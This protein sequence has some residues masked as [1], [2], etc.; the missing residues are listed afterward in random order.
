VSPALRIGGFTGLSCT[1]YPGLLSAVVFCQG[2]PW[3]CS[4][5]HNPHLQAPLAATPIA[6]RDIERF[7]ERRRGL[8]DAVVFS[9]GEPTLQSGVA[10]AMRGAKQM[11]FRVG[12]HTAGI[13]PRR[14]KAL[15]P[16]TDWVAMD[17]KAP[18]EEYAVTT[19]AGASG[20]TAFESMQLILAS[21]VEYEFRTTVHP[22]LLTPKSLTTLAHALAKS[23][24]RNYVLQE[25]R[26]RGCATAELQNDDRSYLVDSFC[27]PLE[28][29]FSSFSVRHA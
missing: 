11:G 13:Y 16:L 29:L 17:I 6:W 8:L 10:D 21:G 14:L 27:R 26:A 20:N 19:G 5:C 23:G 9:G 3:R 18:F 4:Y 15:L 7:L 2:C 22:S 12:L 28:P 25:F 1:D 24:V